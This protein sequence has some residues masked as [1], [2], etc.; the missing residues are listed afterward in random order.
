LSQ[1]AAELWGELGALLADEDGLVVVTGGLAE[2]RDAPG[3]KT[4]DRAIVDGLVRG[5]RAR[6]RPI[7]Q[8]VETI[9]PDPATDGTGLA[10]FREGHVR[11]L[12]R[13][14]PQARRFSM[15][16]S[17]DVVI[18][19]GGEAGTRSVLDMALAIERP[20]LPLPFAGGASADAWRQQ[21]DDICRWFRMP[22]DEATGFERVRVHD[23]GAPEVRVLAE[24]VRRCLMR[25]F[26]QTC[27]VIMRF[28]DGRDAVFDD[29]ICPALRSLGLQP[30][31]TDRAVPHGNVVEAIRDGLRHCHLAIAD[32]TDDRPNVMYELGMAHALD[33]PVILLRRAELDGSLASVPFDVQT[34]SILKYRDDMADLRRRLEGAVAAIR[35]AMSLTDHL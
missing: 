6:G 7:E 1:P 26:T 31:R 5:L 28:Q 21:R 19:I 25:G 35:G 17:A 34:E 16:H 22:A 4:A 12:A 8:R 29:A 13:R 27:F 33:K 30:W 24:Q 9:L 10:R 11:V 15:V 23:L 14:T 20:I 3:A 32:I 2:R 18:A